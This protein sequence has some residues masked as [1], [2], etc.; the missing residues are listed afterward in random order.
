MAL[1]PR[2]IARAILCAGAVS[3]VL[4]FANGVIAGLAQCPSLGCGPWH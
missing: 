3:A 4:H 1:S 2:D